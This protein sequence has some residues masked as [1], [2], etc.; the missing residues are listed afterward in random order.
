M[1]RWSKDS[2]FKYSSPTPKIIIFGVGIL[3][4]AG[5]V[6]GVE[7]IINKLYTI[8]GRN[9]MCFDTVIHILI[10]ASILVFIISILEHIFRSDKRRIKY[11]VRKR[12][13]A[14]TMGNPLHLIDGE[15]EPSIKVRNSDKGYIVR[16]GCASAKFEDV[17]TLATTI[18]D[19]LQNKYG[20]YAV[21]F[22]EEDIAG[23][24]VD[25]YIEDVVS[26]YNRQSVYKSLDDVISHPTRIY[27]NGD[28]YID[29][30]RVLNASTI[31]A[32]RSR[33]GKSTAGISTFLIPTLMQGRDDFGS[34]VT[35]IDPKNAELSMC[36]Y[37][38]SPN[39]DGNV[40]HILDA[41]RDFNRLRIDRQKIINDACKKT[42]KAHKWH[43]KE[44]N[45]KRC[46]LFI[47]EFISLQDLFPKKPSKENPD[48]CITEFQGL[49]RQIA[50]QGAS[51]GCFLILS[52]AEASVGTGGLESAV[53]NA[54][55]IR[56]LFKPSINEAR[57][58]WSSDKLEMMRERQYS[59]GDAWFSADDGIN[60]NV[61]FVKFPRLEFCEYEVLSRLLASY[62]HDVDGSE[63]SSVAKKLRSVPESD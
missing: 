36:P 12:L 19:C 27:I 25:Y 28:D 62:Y 55:G 45:L 13:C 38:L 30:L 16:I 6:K 51:A 52:T 9:P 46:L 31:L 56:V 17:S 1:G 47:D 35:I 37:V 24:F 11:A 48:Y 40:E 39:I 58:L 3:L 4:M 18:S 10:M 23:R 5:I 50:T 49:L 15:I 42:G 26:G 59:A 54:C 63:A 41:I 7:V 14:F 53:N 43:D 29:L 8:I 33:S 32:G 57:F 60:D 22:K 2:Y 20:N 44:L 21:V 34:V 61:S